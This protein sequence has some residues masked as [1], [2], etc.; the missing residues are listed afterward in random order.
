MECRPVVAFK[1]VERNA[2]ARAAENEAAPPGSPRSGKNRKNGAQKKPGA[3]GATDF[4]TASFNLFGA[5]DFVTASFN[6]FLG[7]RGAF[8]DMKRFRSLSRRFAFATQ[9]ERP[10]T[11]RLAINQSRT[12]CRLTYVVLSRSV[13]NA[14]ATKIQAIQRGYA[15]R[16]KIGMALTHISFKIMAP[17]SGRP[18]SALA[19]DAISVASLMSSCGPGAPGGR[20]GE[21][22][23]H[24]RSNTWTAYT[25]AVAS[26]SGANKSMPNRASL[27]SVDPEAAANNRACAG[28]AMDDDQ[29]ADTDENAATKRIHIQHI[30]QHIQQQQLQRPKSA[31]RPGS[32]PPG[33]RR[34]VRPTDDDDGHP[35]T[36]RAS[37]GDANQRPFASPQ[38]PSGAVG[39]GSRVTWCHHF[40]I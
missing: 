8:S 20:A 11:S 2:Q 32:A 7:V 17:Q 3:V 26:V 9:M 40:E 36:A 14:A 15:V 37:T 6:L 29:D 31:H 13:Q 1:V 10:P 24:V 23:P 4:A 35:A 21:I 18:T 39:R 16:K 30:Q 19:A 27:V 22:E 28:R 12:S 33:G 25:V 5:T 34:L 38:P